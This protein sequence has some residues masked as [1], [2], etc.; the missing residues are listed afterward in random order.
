MKKSGIKLFIVF[1]VAITNG[2]FA[3]ENQGKIVFERKTNLEKKFKDLDDDF[4]EYIKLHKFKI[5]EFDL[6]YND[7]CSIFKPIESDEADEMSWATNRNTIYIN[8]T[9]NQR[10]F[11]MDLWGQPVIINDTVK[12]REWKITNSKRKIAGYECR[13]AIWQKN[14]STRIYA[15]FCREIPASVGPEGISGLPGAIL[16]LATEDGSIV[17]FAKKIEFTI[18]EQKQLVIDKK[19]K[20]EFST[21]AFKVFIQENYGDTPWGANLFESLFRWV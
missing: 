11:S 6:I 1:L 4:K 3:Q 12:Q 2:I 13:K 18:P 15:W 20:K 5:D 8:A 17:Y 7:T 21:A 10:V 9:T 14:D 19:K 16:G